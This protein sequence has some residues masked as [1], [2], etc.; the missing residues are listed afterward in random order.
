MY[1]LRNEE[2]DYYCHINYG[3]GR[4]YRGEEMYICYNCNKII[5]RFCITSEY[6]NSG[7]KNS[8]SRNRIINK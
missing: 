3:C 7:Y 6:E 5:C 8:C 2:D 4:K 1:P